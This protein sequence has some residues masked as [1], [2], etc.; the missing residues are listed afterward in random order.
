[1]RS[2]AQRSD[3]RALDEPL[4]GYYL[5]NTDAPH[6]GRDELVEIL[7]TEAGSIIDDVILGSCDRPVL[8]MKQ[9]VHHLIPE[10]DIEF[11]DDCVNVLLIRDP[12]EVIAS[13]VN[14]LPN[15]TMRDVGL[16]RQRELFDDL[17]ARQQE[18]PVLDARQLLLDPQHVLR[19]LCD[20]VGIE[21]DEAMLSWPPG[22]Q[23]EDGPWARYW[24]DNVQR[25]TGF[26]P[27][28]PSEREV[29][30][31]CLPLLEQCRAHYEEMSPF[32]IAAPAEVN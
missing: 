30:E 5:A 21:W 3:T 14:Q 12:A 11:L 10:L 1:M 13:L 9:M 24:Y 20:R 28:R 2:F 18:P 32:A 8:F 6:P 16:Q 22:P 31:H 27:Y 15:P 19:E 26:T 7:E 25:S 17:R 29:P 23:P 4:Y